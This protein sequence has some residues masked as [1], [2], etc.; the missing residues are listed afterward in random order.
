VPCT[1]LARCHYWARATPV[2]ANRRPPPHHRVSRLPDT[3]RRR[4][5]ERQS[6]GAVALSAERRLLHAS[7]FRLA[8]LTDAYHLM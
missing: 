4:S 8:R 3:S 7:L 5:S 2:P 6:S 1:T